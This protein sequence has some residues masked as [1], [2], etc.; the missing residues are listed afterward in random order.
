MKTKIIFSICMSVLLLACRKEND[1]IRLSDTE[2]ERVSYLNQ[3]TGTYEGVSDHWSS[4]PQY[5]DTVLT[6]VS[7]HDTQ[8]VWVIMQLGSLDS[9]LNLR[10]VYDQTTV[11][12][13]ENLKFSAIGSHY[14]SWGG[15]SGAGFLSVKFINDSLHYNYSQKCGIPCNSGINFNISRN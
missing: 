12:T 5:I 11:I 9:C 1:V 10:I 13:N 15:G 3:W 8:D 7:N 6:F 2:A 14:S 4:Y